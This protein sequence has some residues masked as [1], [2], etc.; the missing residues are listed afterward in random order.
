MGT[1]NMNEWIFFDREVVM[2][3]FWQLQEFLDIYR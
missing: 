2:V 3:L 1:K